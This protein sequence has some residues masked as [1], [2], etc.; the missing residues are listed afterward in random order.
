MAFVDSFDFK[1]ES[2]SDIRRL[3]H[4]NNRVGEN[5]PVVYVLN[6]K[7]KAYIGETVNAA[8]RAEQHLAN[9]DKK[10]L[11]EI[12]IISDSDFNKSVILD[13]ES[14]LIKHMA[15][16]DKYKLLNGNNGIQDHD[17]YER[18]RYENEFKKIWEQLRK[19]GI[20][21]NSIE[22]I[23]NSELFKYS[24]YKSLGEEQLEAEREILAAFAL[25]RNDDGGVRIIVRGGA[26]TGKTI[27]AIYLMKLLSDINSKPVESPY[28]DDYLE[29]D[30]ESIYASE[31]LT[32]IEKIGIVFPQTSL[33]ASIKD[34]FRKVNSLNPSMVL[35]AVNVVKDYLK[36]G[37][38]YD[39]LIVDEGHRL[40]CRRPNGKGNLANNG[41]FK[42]YC[43][44]LGLDYNNASELDWLYMCSEHLII[45]R[46][47]WQTV[48][49]SDMDADEFM[50]A[51]TRNWNGALIQQFLS[52]QWRCQGGNDYIDYLKDIWNC[53]ASKFRHIDNYDFKI[54]DDAGKM[55]ED[56][57]RLNEEY[58][59]CRTVA[60]YAWKWKSKKDKEAYDII[61]DGNQYRWNSTM[62]NWI[63]K[64]CSVSEIGCIHTVQGYDLNYVG[65]II[66]EDVKY[67]PANNRIIADKNNYYDSLGKSGVS[68]D[69]EMLKE[70]L[71]N[72]YRTLMT[73]G[74][75]GT[76]VYVCDKELRKYMEQYIE[77]K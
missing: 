25:H 9:P 16:D 32:G 45:F 77:K 57:R 31:N 8:R 72:I 35:G 42:H 52:A 10:R 73:R 59:L 75:R 34:V 58:G 41:T 63:N 21:N 61:I 64:K 51:T 1:I 60:G 38:K 56:I 3:K 39:L 49:P 17:Y 40:K 66:G 55:V 5:W 48:R 62:D 14:Y 50:A 68:D 13:L 27:L 67:D 23:E 15:A 29:D 54:Y 74:I 19:K 69:P 2:I 36:T 4:N 43:E 22:D 7:N 24:P 12:R 28:I 33:R 65:V 71:I 53:K 44:A 76:Y 11:T 70:Y 6:N 18:S 37:K 47:D 20:V 30:T 46:D 26:G